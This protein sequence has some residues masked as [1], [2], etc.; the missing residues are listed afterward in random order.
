[1][2]LQS[3]FLLFRSQ[4]TL[5]QWRRSADPVWIGFFIS[6]LA[7]AYVENHQFQKSLDFIT[8]AAANTFPFL[9]LSAMLAA[10]AKASGSDNLIAAA[11]Q[12][13]GSKAIV[14]AALTGALSPFCSCGVIPVI[15]ALLSM[16]VPLGPVMAF[17]LASP[18][19]DPA[20]FVITSATLGW[21]FALA[22]T[23][24]AIGVGL[25]GGFGVTI[26]MSHHNASQILRAGI[27]NGGCA[28]SK[29]RNPKAVVWKFWT[30]SARLKVFVE[31]SLQ[32][33]QFLAKWLLV[34]YLLESLMVA[35]LPN[36]LIARYAGG[37]GL[38]PILLATAIG[39]PSYLNGYAALPL[40]SGF[41]QQGMS[42]G[43]AMAF[44]IAGGV[45]SIPAAIA[46]WAIAK[47]KVFA[48]YVGFAV[49]GA[50]GSGL[51][52]SA[53]LNYLTR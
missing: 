45:T 3:H 2:K 36:D 12:A 10:Y 26:L 32:T 7:L 14:F 41:M 50:V 18:L 51:I 4:L 42:G 20:M 25:L 17:W 43:A 46:V 1:M 35:Y 21:Q 34:A 37:E 19:M 38:M 31:H 53:F 52:Y 5:S 49:L 44:L 30:D 6:M 8:R 16:G 40:M 29:I 11:F 27:G 28:A 9:I 13:K 15:A 47:P 22:K 39:I 33:I 24:A 48:A 23:I